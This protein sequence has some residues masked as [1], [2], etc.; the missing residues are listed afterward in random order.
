M[1]FCGGKEF[2]EAHMAAMWLQKVEAS[3]SVCFHAGST[4]FLSCSP[5]F[6]LLQDSQSCLAYNG[7]F[8]EFSE[9]GLTFDYLDFPEVGDCVYGKNWAVSLYSESSIISGQ[10]LKPLLQLM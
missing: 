3:G 10:H 8:P 1:N 2:I 9:V 4:E 6:C 7:T 5:F